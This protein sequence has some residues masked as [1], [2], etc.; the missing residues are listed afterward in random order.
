MICYSTQ[1]NGIV[2]FEKGSKTENKA[3][4]FP[5]QKFPKAF[6]HKQTPLVVIIDKQPTKTH[7]MLIDRGVSEGKIFSISINV[8][9]CVVV[10]VCVS[11]K[12]SSN[13]RLE[14]QIFRTIIQHEIS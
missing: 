7:S 14:V 6:Q 12:I 5:P 13:D 9:K 8:D 3:A 2:L 4:K 10:C 11:H 1:S